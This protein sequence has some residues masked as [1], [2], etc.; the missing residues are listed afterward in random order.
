MSVK[1]RLCVFGLAAAAALGHTCAPAAF[2]WPTGIEFQ[3]GFRTFV[4]PSAEDASEKLGLVVIADEIITDMEHSLVVNGRIF[5][6][7]EEVRE[8]IR[9]EFAVTS[10]VGVGLSRRTAHVTPGT[11]A[12]GET[13]AFKVQMLLQS[14]KPEYAMYTV[15]AKDE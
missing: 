3:A 12:P 6:A 15:T 14:E 13:A 7:G 5:N 9:M 11:L 1:I 4:V 8:E 2:D 10:Y